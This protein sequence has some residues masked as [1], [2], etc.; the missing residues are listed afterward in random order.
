MKV[1]VFSGVQILTR[2]LGR[3][4]RSRRAGI[5]VAVEETKPFEVSSFVLGFLAGLIE[6]A[7]AFDAKDGPRRSREQAGRNASEHPMRPERFVV[8]ADPSV[9]R[10]GRRRRRPGDRDRGGVIHRKPAR[11]LDRGHNHRRVPAL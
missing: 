2:R 6:A 5:G 1:L 10:E 9:S 7:A 3:S 8:D 4:S 11:P